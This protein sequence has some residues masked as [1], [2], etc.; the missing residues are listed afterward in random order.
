M[1]LKLV[2]K[3]SLRR[4][5]PDQVVRVGDVWPPSQPT[6]MSSPMNAVEERSELLVKERV[7][8]TFCTGCVISANVGNP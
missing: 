7:E 8:R 4:H 5:Y 6:A 2:S 3:L 1:L